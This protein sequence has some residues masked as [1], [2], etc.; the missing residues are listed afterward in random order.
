MSS[1][2]SES[3][4]FSYF[5]FELSLPLTPSPLVDV[6][7]WFLFLV[8]V[9]VILITILGN[10][11]TLI[12]IARGKI[13]SRNSAGRRFILS[14]AVADLS[15]GLFVMIPRAGQFQWIKMLYV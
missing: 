11:F 13:L 12:G 7:R 9:L 4:M 14:L 8:T 10:I 3:N 15:V 1:N 6:L 2:S 5:P